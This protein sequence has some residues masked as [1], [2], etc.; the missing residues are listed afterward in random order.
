MKDF[1]FFHF[2]IIHNMSL[3][4]TVDYALEELRLLNTFGKI[5]KIPRFALLLNRCPQGF[6]KGI[7]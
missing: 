5:K 3:F 7:N 2:L 4:N 1:N 6:N